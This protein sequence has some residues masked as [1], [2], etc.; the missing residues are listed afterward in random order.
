MS[1]SKIHEL[2]VELFGYLGLRT[3]HDH[4]E[5]RYTVVG[6]GEPPE[7][8]FRYD[9]ARISERRVSSDNPRWTE[10]DVRGRGCTPE[11]WR[12]FGWSVRGPVREYRFTKG[13]NVLAQP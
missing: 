4:W 7:D 3:T 2:P 6:I 5:F 11:R 10:V 1:L 12:S 9:D 13:T 8:M